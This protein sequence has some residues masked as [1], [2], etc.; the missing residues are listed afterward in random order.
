MNPR[1]PP[2]FA[3]FSGDLMVA[4]EARL[5]AIERRLEAHSW[6]QLGI[7]LFQMITIGVMVLVK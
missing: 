4:V 5:S 7:L 1:E 2:D 3:R 6:L